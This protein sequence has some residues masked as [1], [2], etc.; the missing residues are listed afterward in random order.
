MKTL[1]RIVLGL[2]SSLIIATLTSFDSISSSV[3]I[4]TGQYNTK[5]HYSKSW[6]GLSNCKSSIVKTS[7]SADQQKG[8][9]LCGWED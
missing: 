4:C 3:Y 5:Y 2:S 7:R 9:T 6:R 1:Q 8:R